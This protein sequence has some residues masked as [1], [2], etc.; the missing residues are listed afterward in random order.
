V[1]QDLTS[2]NG[3]ISYLSGLNNATKY[4]EIGVSKGT[5][6]FPVD[7]RFKI[8]VDPCFRFDPSEHKQ[9]GTHFFPIPSD[10]FFQKLDDNAPDVQNIFVPKP[11]AFDIIFIDGLHT[12]EQSYRDFENS[13]R[14]AHDKTLWLIDDTVPSDAYSAI[15]DM[16]MAYYKRSQAGG[17]SF[18]HGDIYKSPWHGDVYKTIFAIHDYHPE[19]SYC[20]RI[21]EN[22]ETTVWRTDANDRH[23][24]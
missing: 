5:T 14:Y 22:T 6:F 12:F 10:E 18:W 4:L 15:P 17:G 20:T 21:G 16:E 11:F 3:R 8:A 9:E 2:Y 24:R 7:I 23:P 13:L 19:C 1:T